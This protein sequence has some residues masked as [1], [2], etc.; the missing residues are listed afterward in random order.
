[1][2]TMGYQA[3]HQSAGRMVGREHEREL[4]AELL[5]MT[6]QGRGGLVLVSG[7]AGIGKSTLVEDLLDTATEQGALVLAGGCYDLTTT[8]PYGPWLEIVRASPH[9]EGLSSLST[10]LGSNIEDEAG[11]ANRQSA[12]F[13]WALELFSRLSADQPLLLVLEDLH[14]ADEASLEFLRHIARR[15]HDLPAMLVVTY[16]SDEIT[17]HHPLYALVPMLVREA[18]AERIAL[19]PLNEESIANWIRDAY[20]LAPSAEY[21]LVRYLAHRAEGN[22]F[23]IKELMRTLEEDGMLR[24]AGDSWELLRLD[25]VTVPI[26]LRQ[27]VETRLLRLS[28]EQ[29]EWLALAA[30]IGHQVMLDVWQ[31]VAG[32]PDDQFGEGIRNSIAAGLVEQASD[33]TSIQFRHALIREALYEDT[34]PLERRSWHRQVAE[35]LLAAPDPDPDR[36]AHHLQ[37]AGDDRA[38]EWL[39]RAGDRAY[40][41]AY[42]LRT[43][44]E[45]YDAAL[46]ML[47]R[48]TAG[49]IEYGWLLTRYALGGRWS[50]AE[51]SARHLRRALE[52][53]KVEGDRAL[54]AAALWNLGMVRVIIGEP[55]I[56]DMES[57]IDLVESLTT[58]ERRELAGRF[59]GRGFAPRYLR[60]LLGVWYAICGHYQMA[61]A[62]VET[63][64]RE[65]SGEGQFD[66][67]IAGYLHGIRGY[68]AWARGN[69]EQSRYEYLRARDIFV[70]LGFQ[71]H[72]DIWTLYEF[73]DIALDA[74]PDDLAGR[75]MR[76][77]MMKR[78]ADQTISKI[79]NDPQRVALFALLAI[80]GRWAEILDVGRQY[81][82]QRHSSWFLTLAPAWIVSV[83]R[84]TANYDLAWTYINKLF[85]GG[86]M[87]EPSE[88]ARWYR[89]GLHIQR[90][91]AGILLDIG[92]L[93]Q[94]R[95]WLEAQDRWLD[96][97]GH[98]PG[99]AET[100]LLWA[101]YHLGSG[102]VERARE[103]AEQAL[104]L[105]HQA[106]QPLIQLAIQRFI[107]ELDTKEAR[108]D[109]ASD[110]FV[111]AMR[112]ANA[113]A[114]PFER[115]LTLLARAELQVATGESKKAALSL[116][117]AEEIL[118]ALEARPALERAERLRGEDERRARYGPDAPGGLGRAG[119]RGAGETGRQWHDHERSPGISI[120]ARTVGQHLGSIYSKLGVANRTEATRCTVEEEHPDCLTIPADTASSTYRVGEGLRRP[121]DALRR[122][123]RSN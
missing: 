83:A 58:D 17:R 107:G 35:V 65:Q 104:E 19:Q 18:A 2:N 66:Q 16:R 113:C 61:E 22:P 80:E 32:I 78:V 57:A 100:R 109:D 112:L 41:E 48:D 82:H 92:D 55:G 72:A 4:L 15:L 26:L 1:M 116:A 29:R 106:R 76:E 108:F 89:E 10:I 56:G 8:P 43:A 114:A 59:R 64:E 47:E 34:M 98:V 6:L 81:L 105:T 120:S 115:A 88:A 25:D 46:A 24:R 23:Y 121:H 38:A 87:L 67:A 118:T 94:A 13:D 96:W 28:D 20:A 12:L 93:D 37:Q 73:Q 49:R 51:R 119:S 5:G 101:R 77:R 63:S 102:N 110:R 71:F 85:P 60:A 39:I 90:L 27:L 99:R 79:T 122:F 54:E 123:H 68:V 44:T 103:E 40:Y 91:A 53:A 30:V 97:S 74:Y 70:A 9:V 95:R 62:F 36:V 75:E 33:R 86:P 3:R 45:R 21:R 42:A 50:R 7:E 14:W 117:E 52:I 111:E 69:P 11:S 31:E 84:H